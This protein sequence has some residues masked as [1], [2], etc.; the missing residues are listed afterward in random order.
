MAVNVNVKHCR[1]VVI[2]TLC[3][4]GGGHG[5]TK[6]QE[7]DV[8]VQ[9]TRVEPNNGPVLHCICQW[10]PASLPMSIGS[11]QSV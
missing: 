1:M 10:S 4:L 6:D 7:D 2:L 3:I 8:V 9:R 5:G 11:W